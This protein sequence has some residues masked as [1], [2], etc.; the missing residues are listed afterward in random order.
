MDII[1]NTRE[2]TIIFKHVDNVNDVIKMNK[3][4]LF[5]HTDESVRYIASE[6]GHNAIKTNYPCDVTVNCK[7]V[8]TVIKA[9]QDKYLEVTNYLEKI[10]NDENKNKEI[11]MSTK[12][13]GGRGII[14][15][16]SMGWKI[17]VEKLSSDT[18]RVSAINRAN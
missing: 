1:N 3:Y 5:N 17:M 8:D 18:Y 13:M 15:I 7:R 12:K 4:L 11:K 2:N 9:N 14:S 6:L 16:I 10:S